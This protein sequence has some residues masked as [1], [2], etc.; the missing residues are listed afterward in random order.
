MLLS[1]QAKFHFGTLRA[2]SKYKANRSKS[3][4]MSRYDDVELHIGDSH[5]DDADYDIKDRWFGRCVSFVKI[6]ELEGIFI[7]SYEFVKSFRSY[8]EQTHELP[9][10]QWWPETKARKQ[11]DRLVGDIIHIRIVPLQSLKARV[12]MVRD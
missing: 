8:P 12:C 11:S 6:G 4:W 5:G 3:T 7:Q 2:A 1:T 9:I 10:F